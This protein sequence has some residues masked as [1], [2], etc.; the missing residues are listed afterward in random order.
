MWA[1][2]KVHYRTL[3]LTTTSITFSDNMFWRE[4]QEVEYKP[5]FRNHG[6]GWFLSSCFV[7]ASRDANLAVFVTQAP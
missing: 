3:P 6:M 5:L 1:E 4:R 2:S 7:S